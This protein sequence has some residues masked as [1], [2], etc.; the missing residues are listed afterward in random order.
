MR[1][2]SEENI[3]F[4]FRE[5]EPASGHEMVSREGNV[6]N[7]RSIMGGNGRRKFY[8]RAVEVIELSNLRL[9][10]SNL[11]NVIR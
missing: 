1:G 4:V 7:K 11:T 3:E 9:G 5:N 6:R 10:L 8:E 2:V